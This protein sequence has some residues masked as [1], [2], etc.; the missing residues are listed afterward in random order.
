VGGVPAQF[1][2]E[3][4]DDEQEAFRAEADEIP[5]GGLAPICRRA[6]P[7]HGLEGSGGTPV[8]STVM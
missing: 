1:I 7:R 2:R 8:N 4:T 3:L 5:A 6:A